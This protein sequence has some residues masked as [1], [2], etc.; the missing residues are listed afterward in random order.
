M[1]SEDIDEGEWLIFA[2]NNQCFDF[3]NDSSE[4]IYTTE[5]G[6]AVDLVCLVI[7]NDL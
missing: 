2:A 4:D 1:D 6:F 3:L 5:D 7:A